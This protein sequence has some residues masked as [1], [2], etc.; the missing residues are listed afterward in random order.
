MGTAGAN[1]VNTATEPLNEVYD[2]IYNMY[3]ALLDGETHLKNYLAMTYWTEDRFGNKSLNTDMLNM[4]FSVCINN[5]MDMSGEVVG[6]AKYI[7]AMSIHN[8]NNFIEFIKNNI[9]DEKVMEGLRKNFADVL[10]LGSHG[11]DEISVLNGNKI[12]LVGEG[13]DTV[14]GNNGNDEIYGESGNDKLYGG[15]GNDSIYGGSGDDYMEG[16]EGADTYYINLGDGNDE[17]YNYDYYGWSSDK[18]VYGAGINP[19]D[20]KVTRAGND[21]LLSNVSSGDSVRLKNAYSDWGNHSWIG[22]IEFADGTSWNSDEIRKFAEME[23]TTIGGISDTVYHIE[24]SENKSVYDMGGEDTINLGANMLDV[25]FEKKG[26]D[27]FINDGADG[28]IT[29]KDWYFGDAHKI[30]NISTADGYSI[31]DSQVQLLID[32]MAGFTTEEG[33]SDDITFNSDT[34]QKSEML[35]QFWTKK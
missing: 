19:E 24:M 20:I 4:Y 28:S 30:E 17:I 15:S 3:Y 8:N 18:I 25:V 26:N 33:M 7:R 21:L 10:L 32:S 29:V 27:L 31:T 23:N 5:G 2:C 22:S 13:N 12:V 35:A 11:A 9:Y 14:Y 6:M 1:P 34:T 16:D